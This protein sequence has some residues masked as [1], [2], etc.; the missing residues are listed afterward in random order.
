MS[1]TYTFLKSRFSDIM[2]G[3][4]PIGMR[5]CSS[6]IIRKGVSHGMPSTNFIN[7]VKITA[8]RSESES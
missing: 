7:I 1:W 8:C 3:V 5:G 4:C 2:M 6:C